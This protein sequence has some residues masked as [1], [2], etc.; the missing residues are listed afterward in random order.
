MLRPRHSVRDSKEEHSFLP[1]PGPEPFLPAMSFR[2]LLKDPIC[3]PEDVGQPIPPS[4]HAVSVSLPRW[5]DVVD[6]EEKKPGRWPGSPMAIPAFLFTGQYRSWPA[7]SAG[8]G[9]AFL[10]HPYPPQRVAQTSSTVPALGGRK[11]WPGGAFTL[12]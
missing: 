12:S 3:R 2:D 6:Y 5:Q 8:I 4:P 10:S 11:L 7:K 1:R 9:L